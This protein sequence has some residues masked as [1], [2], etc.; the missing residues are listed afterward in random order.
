[1]TLQNI[2][3]ASKFKY[4]I[5]SKP[6]HYLCIATYTNAV[7]A[8]GMRINLLNTYQN[9]TLFLTMTFVTLQE[10]HLAGLCSCCCGGNRVSLSSLTIIK[11][12]RQ[13]SQTITS[14]CVVLGSCNNNQTKP[15]ID[16]ARM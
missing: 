16:M 3:Y 8:F 5:I 9:P 6:Q 1:M 15:Q 13:S 14:Q 4:F 2:Q 10:V 7:C 12:I 11:Y